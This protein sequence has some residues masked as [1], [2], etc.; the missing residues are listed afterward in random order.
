MQK[1]LHVLL[2]IKYVLFLVVHL[3]GLDIF[4]HDEPAYPTQE[5]FPDL[6][7]KPDLPVLT[8]M[9]ASI[10]GTTFYGKA[11]DNAT[12]GETQKIAK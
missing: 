3:V 7:S 10:S 4:E 5:T 6:D 8:D 1:L 11:F 9:R 12:Y 2:V